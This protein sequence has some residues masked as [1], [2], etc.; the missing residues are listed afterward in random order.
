MNADL[1]VDVGHLSSQDHAANF[2]F[3]LHTFE[4]SP[5]RLSELHGLR[6]NPLLLQVHLKDT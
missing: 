1:A 4:R 2:T 3:H 6:N 5:L